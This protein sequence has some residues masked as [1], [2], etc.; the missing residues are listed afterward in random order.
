MVSFH[1]SPEA[2]RL[3][4]RFGRVVGH[5]LFHITV[6]VNPWLVIVEGFGINLRVSGIKYQA[7]VMPLPQAGH[8]MQRCGKMSLLWRSKVGRQQGDLGAQINPSNFYEPS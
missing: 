8:D 4:T 3:P 1:K 6:K 2:D 5:R 7:G